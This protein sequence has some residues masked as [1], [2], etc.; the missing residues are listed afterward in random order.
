[1]EKNKIYHGNSLEILRTFPDESIDMCVTSPPYYGLRDYGIEPIIW[2]GEENCSHEWGKKFEPNFNK[3]H[4]GESSKDVIIR[5][6]LNETNKKPWDSCFCS[7]CGAWKGQLGLEPSPDLFIKHLTD[8]FREVKRVLKSTGTLW[9][10]IG[11]SYAGSGGAGKP[12]SDYYENKHKQFG[13]VERKEQHSLPTKSYSDLGIKQK[14]LIGI[15]WML[16]FSLRSDGWYLRQDIIWAKATSGDVR[17]GN[18]MPESCTDR[19]SKSHEYIFLLSKSK[20]YYYDNEAIKEPLS[21]S[22]KIRYKSG[23]NG[24]NKR[25]WPKKNQQNNFDKYMGSEK[26]KQA[27]KGNRRSIWFVKTKPFKESHFAIFPPNLII[28]IIKAGVPKK[29]CS[30]CGI[31]YERK[32]IF[33]EKNRDKLNCKDKNDRGVT[34]TTAGLKDLSKYGKK[35]IQEIQEIKICDC[36]NDNYDKGIVLD[37]FFGSGT[38]GMTAKENNVYYVGIEKNPEYIELAEKRIKNTVIPLF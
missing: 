36:N 7:K 8:I 35:E 22:S 28:P 30:Q 33:K 34:I 38:T 4:H 13:K 18:A 25:D 3:P 21:E 17:M 5:E 16:A 27:E 6:E 10:N 24:N 12:G 19:C 32:V 9:V 26:A 37:P 2:D 23:W 15:P 14:D 29:V 20:D 11:D 31:P 1:M